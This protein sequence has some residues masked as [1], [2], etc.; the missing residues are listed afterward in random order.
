MRHHPARRTL[1]T[2]LVVWFTVVTVEPAALHSCPV[3]GA[4]VAA[5]LTPATA[6]HHG[7]APSV[8][9]H[10]P[11]ADH[12][13]RHEGD[14]H[15]CACIGDCSAS[16]PAATLPDARILVVPVAL[17][18]PAPAVPHVERPPATAPDFLR[19]YANGPP[20]GRRIA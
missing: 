20:A 12:G 15:Q 9:E 18:D 19:P 4:P 2:L 8:I 11:G 10:A 16:N 13:Q 5:M 3:H 17:R 1:S 14:S 7:Q 6:A